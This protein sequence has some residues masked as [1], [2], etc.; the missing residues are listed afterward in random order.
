MTTMTINE[1][2]YELTEEDRAWCDAQAR[3]QIRETDE[4]LAKS[5][6]TRDFNAYE[7][8]KRLEKHTLGWQGQLVAARCLGVGI[9]L[10]HQNRKRGDLEHAIEVRTIENPRYGLRFND[11]DVLHRAFVVVRMNGRWGHCKGWSRFNEE[12]KARC[13]EKVYDR[14]GKPQTFWIL[15]D[16]HLQPMALMASRL[17]EVRQGSVTKGVW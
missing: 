3:N 9:L 7:P 15:Q 2:S 4:W 8:E 12:V 16:I 17:A 13:Q 5:S 6:R 11:R 14:H 10:G 1:W